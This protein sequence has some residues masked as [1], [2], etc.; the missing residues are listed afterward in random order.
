MM[1]RIIL[2][3]ALLATAAKCD[4]GHRSAARP[5]ESQMTKEVFERIQPGMLF[6]DVLRSSGAETTVLPAS[7]PPTSGVP[8]ECLSRARKVHVFYH[9]PPAESYYVFVDGSGR[10]VC[11]AQ[12]MFAA[13]Y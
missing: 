1:A 10:I 5:P 6:N 7:P 9:S 12:G 3:A 13:A 11:T 8:N 2:C 4:R